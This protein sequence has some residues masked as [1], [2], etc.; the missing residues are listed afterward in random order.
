MWSAGAGYGKCFN[1]LKS[2]LK[3]VGRPF[4]GMCGPNL[5]ATFG[6]ASDFC[7]ETGFLF[8]CAPEDEGKVC[9]PGMG[10]RGGAPQS[11]ESNGPWWQVPASMALVTDSNR[12]PPLWQC[13]QGIVQVSTS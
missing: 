13:F 9:V 2:T 12:S 6:R 4:D 5:Q 3:A 10:Q 1:I 11:S 7:P 8:Q